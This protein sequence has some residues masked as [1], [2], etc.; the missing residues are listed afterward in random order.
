MKRKAKA[1]ETGRAKGAAGAKSA[2]KAASGRRAGSRSAPEQPRLYHHGALK[3]ALLTA[4]EEILIQDGLAGLT[5]REA[6]RRT[7]VSHAAP[8]NHFGDIK[9]LLSELAAVGF[10]RLAS[11]LRRAAAGAKSADDTMDAIGRAY[12]AFAQTSPGLFHLMYRSE[13]LDFTRPAL[14]DALTHVSNSLREPVMHRQATR[15]GVAK[16]PLDTV[17]AMATSWCLVHGFATL[18]IDRRLDPMLVHVPG[19]DKVS[20]LLDAVLANIKPKPT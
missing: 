8:K 19:S 16:G 18:L 17:A 15:E 5:L 13:A 9:G 4:A 7:G 12:V 11:Q 14:S 10:Q 3:Q 1:P 20:L 2:A 6:A